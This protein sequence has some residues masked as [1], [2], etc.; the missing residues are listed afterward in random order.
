MANQAKAE[1]METRS[2]APKDNWQLVLV[3]QVGCFS[4]DQV[5]RFDLTN[6]LSRT[7]F[8]RNL[9]EFYGLCS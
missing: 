4:Q 6:R 3:A 1:M 5:C 7:V 9:L 2:L 8:P